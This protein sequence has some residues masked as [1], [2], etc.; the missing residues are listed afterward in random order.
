MEVTFVNRY[1]RT[2]APCCGMPELLAPSTGL[3]KSTRPCGGMLELLAPKYVTSVNRRG[4]LLTT[5]ES[6]PPELSSQHP[7]VG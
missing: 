4:N 2:K 3:R 7:R 6:L 5:G 1:A